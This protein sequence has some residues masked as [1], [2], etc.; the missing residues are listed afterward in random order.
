M[1]QG[2]D[3]DEVY[4]CFSNVPDDVQ[5]H[6]ARGLDERSTR[7]CLSCR[8]HHIYIH[9]DEEYDIGPRLGSRLGLI[10]ALGLNLDM[11]YARR[12]LLYPR[13]NFFEQ[14]PPGVQYGQVIVLDQNAVSQVQP[15][16]QSSAYPHRVFVYDSQPR[17]GLASVGNTDRQAAHCLNITRR[18][19][20]DTAH[21]LQEIERYA[22]APEYAGCLSLDHS[23]DILRTHRLAVLQHHLQF[24]V[25][26]QAFEH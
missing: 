4:P 26:I 10:H 19:R 13:H 7:Y 2:A 14:D 1:S 17:G 16:I 8:L 15:M 5:S 23:D 25:G 11:K 21:P 24:Q 20:G 12:V 22:F 9:V 18:L 6:A 3:G